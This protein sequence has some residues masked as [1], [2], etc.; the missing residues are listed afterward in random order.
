M[1]VLVIG[2]GRTGAQVLRQLQKNPR[3]TIKTLDPRERPF[4]IEEGIIES[5]DFRE[6]LTPLSLDY[7]LEQAAPDLVVLASATE[8]MGLGHAPGMDIL[9]S[10]LREELASLSGV[11]VLEVA[12]TQER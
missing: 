2:A 8:D 7:V 11:P 10:A 1:V 5:V 3:I 12:R 6:T 4:A 9:A